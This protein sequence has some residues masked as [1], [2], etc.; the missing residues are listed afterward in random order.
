MLMIAIICSFDT[1]CTA[2]CGVVVKVQ[3][4]QPPSACL[5]RSARTCSASLVLLGNIAESSRMVVSHAY[6]LVPIAIS[7][8]VSLAG[9]RECAPR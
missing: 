5:T 6:P 9:C 7:A 3:L 4:V 8:V 1:K 2:G